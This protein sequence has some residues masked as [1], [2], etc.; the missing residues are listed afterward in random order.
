MNEKQLRLMIIF[1]LVH[2]R[3]PKLMP[4]ERAVQFKLCARV[5][6]TFCASILTCQFFFVTRILNRKGIAH[7]VLDFSQGCLRLRYAIEK[8]FA[9]SLYC[10]TYCIVKRNHLCYRNYLRSTGQRQGDSRQ[11]WLAG[12]SKRCCLDENSL[13][14]RAASMDCTPEQETGFRWDRKPHPMCIPHVVDCILAYLKVCD[15]KSCRL[16]SSQYNEIACK[17]LQREETIIFKTIPQLE[18]YLSNIK[19]ISLPFLPSS[20]LTK[21]QASSASPL[22]SEEG[23]INYGIE[24]E[25]PAIRNHNQHHEYSQQQ[26]SSYA[27]SVTNPYRYSHRSFHFDYCDPDTEI[28]QID[29]FFSTFGSQ[30]HRLKYTTDLLPYNFPRSLGHMGEIW[31]GRLCNLEELILEMK[32]G[33]PAHLFANTEVAHRHQVL[34]PRLKSLHLDVLLTD[35]DADRAELFL[36]QLLSITPNIEEI[37]IPG[38]KRFFDDYINVVLAR[39]IISSELRKLSTLNFCLALSDTQMRLLTGKN[40]PLSTLILDLEDLQF[41]GGA[42]NNGEGNNDNVDFENMD[43]D[44]NEDDL[45]QNGLHPDNNNEDGMR[46]EFLRQNQ[47]RRPSFTPIVKSTLQRFLNSLSATLSSLHI[48]FPQNPRNSLHTLTFQQ[49]MTEL[50]FLALGYFAGSVRILDQMPALRKLELWNVQFR[51]CH[52]HGMVVPDKYQGITSVIS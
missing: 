4:G 20:L 21:S 45:Q 14:Y 7:F 15:L 27:D 3:D 22:L 48:C 6:F 50:K 19:P 2:K 24:I 25:W 17:A 33:I 9:Q 23:S 39:V 37:S 5:Y 40:L 43:Q 49:E 32:W 47:N 26:W 28:E 42:E 8:L 41:D 34:L 36:R 16:V 31:K 13:I 35:R 18:T 11:Q 29:H 30:I 51:D 46:H 44:N 1:L 10:D 38:S 52:G 12:E